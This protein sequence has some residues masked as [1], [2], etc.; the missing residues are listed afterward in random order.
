MSTAVF[1]FNHLEPP[2]LEDPYPLYTQARRDAPVFYSPIFQ[3]WIVTRYDDVIAILR[4]PKR[5]SSL[6]L[7][8]TPVNPTSEVQAVLDQIPPEVPMLIT[9]DPPGHTRSRALVSKAFSSGQVARMEP[10]IRAIADALI[11]SFI[12]GGQAEL[13]R[14]Y[15]YPL[16]MT[17][18]L[19]FIG[20]PVADA[21]FIKEW[22]H[23][24]VLLAVPGIGAEQ[25][26][27]S[28]QAEAAFA[29]YAEAII[30]EKQR[31]PQDDVLS[32]LINARVEGE[33]PFD[34]VELITLMQHLL[35]AGHETTTNLLSLTFYHLLRQPERWHAL[36]AD[37]TLVANTLEESLRYDAAVQSMIRTTTQEVQ[38]AD[39]TIPAG[40][41]IMFFF[42]SANR[43]DAAFSD[44]EHF[45]LQRPNAN[46]HLTLGYG[47]HYCIGAPLARLEGRIAVETLMRRIPDLRLAPDYNT[48][49]LPNLFNR[50][51]QQLHVAWG[52]Q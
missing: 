45:D 1:P 16:P 26:L 39:V 52:D 8:R 34:D 3:S 33:R 25:Q 40:D 31:N 44:P 48:A 38:I 30:A 17:A 41:R 50:A 21:D 5:F 32:D 14:Q 23:E 2:H 28:A 42:G 22:T 49:F 18:L 20:L 6:I 47:I 43:D 29:R 37:P 13:V 7:F 27:K 4:D 11:D 46:K 9:E 51:L 19:E 24:H 10:R 35:F 36:R 15:T 12:D